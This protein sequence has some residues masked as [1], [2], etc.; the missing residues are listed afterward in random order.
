MTMLKA[1]WAAIAG[2][3]P[4]GAVGEGAEH[5]PGD[6]EPGELQQPAKLQVVAPK[7]RAVTPIDSPPG[8]A[9]A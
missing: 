1:R 4:A 7:T 2:A 5:D 6:D 9:R 3:E 8:G